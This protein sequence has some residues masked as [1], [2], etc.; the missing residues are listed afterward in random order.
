MLGM[1]HF[2]QSNNVTWSDRNLTVN[3]KINI[4]K[5]MKTNPRLTDNKGQCYKTFCT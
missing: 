5:D 2:E 1:S 3:C 4:Y